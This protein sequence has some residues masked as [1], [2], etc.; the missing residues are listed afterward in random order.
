M[1]RRVKA[2][3]ELTA[4]RDIKDVYIELEIEYT[5]TMLL[6]NVLPPIILTLTRR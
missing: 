1:A 5:N 2:P 3:W 4:M 6:R